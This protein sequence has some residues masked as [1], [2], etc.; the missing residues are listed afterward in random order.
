M[1]S[2]T[3]RPC[4]I[5]KLNN[6]YELRAYQIV[7]MDMNMKISTQHALRLYMKSMSNDNND[8]R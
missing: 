3:L 8:L 5:I 1:I 2:P 7:S 4:M 6:D